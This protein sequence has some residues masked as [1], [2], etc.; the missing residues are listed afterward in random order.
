MQN[1][2]GNKLKV[3]GQKKKLNLAIGASVQSS[4][5]LPHNIMN[6]CA[7]LQCLISLQTGGSVTQKGFPGFHH[8]TCT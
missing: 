1:D 6:C 2:P 7:V 5:N 4:V 3:V 8:L